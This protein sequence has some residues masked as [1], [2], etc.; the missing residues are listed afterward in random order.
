MVKTHRR[1]KL[2][3]A[4]VYFALHTRYC[5][6]TKLYKLL[7]LLDFEHYKNTGRSVT[8]LE[9]YAW[10]M[11]PVPAKLDGELDEPSGDLYKAVRI[12]PEQLINHQRLNVVAKREF[13]PSY[14]SRRELD[15]LERISKQYRLSTAASMVKVTHVKNGAWHTV[16]QNGEGD[17]ALIS[18]ALALEKVA[19]RDRVEKAAQEYDETLKRVG[20]V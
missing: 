15:L 1:E 14:F 7:Y 16:W 5:G 20:A 10:E 3:N 12:E 18:Y 8:G 17:N 13:D 6:K 19:D 9:Y 4:I 11:G 2:L